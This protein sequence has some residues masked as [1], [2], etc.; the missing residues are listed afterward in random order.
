MEK[1]ILETD[2]PYLTPVPY[3]GTRNESSYIPHI[4]SRLAE[5]KGTDMETI[6][7]HTTENAEKLFQ[8]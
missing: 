6:A 8:I 3:R 5:L 4:A 2:S 1:I 7:A